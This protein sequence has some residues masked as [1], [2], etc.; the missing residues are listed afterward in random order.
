MRLPTPT[1]VPT[2]VYVAGPYR[3]DVAANVRFAVRASYE[4]WVRGFV[5][6]TP[7]ALG[8]TLEQYGIPVFAE[9]E[10]SVL[11]PG[12]IAI[13]SRCNAVCLLPGWEASS[14]TLQE[15]AEAERL[16]IPCIELRDFLIFPVR[17]DEPKWGIQP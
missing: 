17:L 15:K 1:P 13:M 8:F 2:L 7:H 16:N 11:M 9:F 3:G 6:I 12:M 14:G 4:L 5:P 10:T